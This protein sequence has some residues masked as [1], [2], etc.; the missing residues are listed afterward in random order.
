MI[1][2]T[3]YLRQPA[4]SAQTQPPPFKPGEGEV[5][6]GEIVEWEEIP[7]YGEVQPDH[8]DQWGGTWFFGRNIVETIPLNLSNTQLKTFQTVYFQLMGPIRLIKYSRVRDVMHTRLCCDVQEKWISRL[9]AAAAKGDHYALK[10]EADLLIIAKEKNIRAVM[11]A[12]YVLAEA[13]QQQVCKNTVQSV[14][15]HRNDPQFKFFFSREANGHFMR[16]LCEKI[17]IREPTERERYTPTQAREI[18]QGHLVKMGLNEDQNKH[19]LYIHKLLSLGNFKVEL[20]PVEFW[21]LEFLAYAAKGDDERLEQAVGY[22]DQAHPDNK[23]ALL[24]AAQRLAEE[25]HHRICCKMLKGKIQ[26]GVQITPFDRFEELDSDLTNKLCKIKIPKSQSTQIKVGAIA[27]FLFLILGMASES[28]PSCLAGFIGLAILGI[29]G[30]TANNA[31]KLERLL[32]L[33]NCALVETANGNVERAKSVITRMPIENQLGFYDL[34][35]LQESHRQAA[36]E[37]GS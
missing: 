17:G 15:I 35:S 22:L 5:H 30:N 7:F 14:L 2:I 29:I 3:T 19:V 12:A 13:N 18:M 33:R 37:K 24:R 28:I 27:T 10:R 31:S 4:H 23:L 16:F 26:T 21:I 8:S 20:H 1:S 11:R 32:V 36:E 34:L 6:P 25:Y 9:L